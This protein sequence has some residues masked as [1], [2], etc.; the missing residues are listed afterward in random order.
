MYRLIPDTLPDAV[1][2]VDMCSRPFNDE[3]EEDGVV[4]LRP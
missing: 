1:S 3:E 2:D 4:P